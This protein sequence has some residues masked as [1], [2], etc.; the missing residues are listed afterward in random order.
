MKANTNR[1]S[2]QFSW[3]GSMYKR[4][5]LLPEYSMM[6]QEA[7]AE[8][9]L[10]LYEEWEKD[11]DANHREMFSGDRKTRLEKMK[12]VIWYFENEG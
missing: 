1:A 2:H 10:E 4:L 5:I 9:L 12:R 7:R 3:M 6:D 11:P 8:K